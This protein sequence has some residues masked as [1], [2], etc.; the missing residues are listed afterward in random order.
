MKNS[1]DAIPKQSLWKRI[2]K[3][4]SCYFFMAGFMIIFFVFTVIPVI[5]AMALSTTYFNV[6]EPPKF[7]GLENYLNLFLK[8]EVFLIALKNTLI[9][10][11]VTGPISYL[12]CLL[13]AWLINEIPAKPRA[14][15]TLLC[16][17]PSISG[18]AY[19]VWTIIFSNDAQG[20]MNAI[21]YD[22]GIIDTPVKW[23][24]DPQYMMGVCIV[25]VLWLSLGTSFLS[26]IAGLQGV[27]KTLYEAAAVDG[28]RNRY[29]EFWFIT[30]PSIKPQLLFGA[31]MSIT[32]SFNI[33]DILTQ[34]VGYPSTDY[35]VHTI[36]NHMQD[37]GNIRFEMGYACAMATVLFLMMIFC[38][39]II[40][41]LL[42]K[43]GT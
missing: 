23:L 10:A 24:S 42:S 21:L 9:F 6:L 4:R 29:Q 25:V 28:I 2:V 16:Y 5:I 33:G 39:K 20:Y 11:A 17:A 30:L 40:Q 37:Y 41:K 3:N 22:L 18:G 15:M 12:L 36:V 7:I 34:L 1:V 31:V 26:F 19:F 43:V 38:N 8:D 14:F 13:L 35:A 32:S 27:D